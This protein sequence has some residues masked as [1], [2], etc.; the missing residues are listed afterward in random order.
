MPTIYMRKNRDGRL[1]MRGPDS[2]WLHRTARRMEEMGYR[3]C[4][5]FEYFFGNWFSR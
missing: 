1:K 4:T 5:W 3:R 2:D